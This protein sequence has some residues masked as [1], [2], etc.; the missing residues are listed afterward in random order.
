ML[1]EFKRRHA[2]S[3]LRNELYPMT[4]D[5][6][7]ATEDALTTFAEQLKTSSHC[8]LDGFLGGDAVKAVQQEI[9]MAKDTGMINEEG[10]LGGGREGS[11]S[12]ASVEKGIRSD[13]LGW[14]ECSVQPDPSTTACSF[15]DTPNDGTW[16]GLEHL[17]A[18]METIAFELRPKVADLAGVKS[19]SKAMLTCYPAAKEGYE[20]AG[21]RYTKHYDNA[22]ANG[23]RLTAIYYPN[24]DWKRSYGGA[25]RLYQT[26]DEDSVHVDVE[27]IADRLV[28]F[29]SDT[30]C[31]HE[32]LPV[33]TQE[34]DRFALTLWFYD[35]SERRTARSGGQG[36]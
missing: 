12:M 9:K 13:K 23:R 17:L 6:W 3:N 29:Y 24:A 16:R 27:P 5:W 22:N 14:F 28:L 33:V 4:K 10:R 25:L 30:R 19:R 15:V 8:V 1:E 18:R 26:M 31:L 20:G 34:R 7:W 36:E 32:V 2:V 11:A 21:A 35:D